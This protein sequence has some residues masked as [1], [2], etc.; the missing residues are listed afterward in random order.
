MFAIVE[1]G[2]KQYMVKEGSIL[3]VE[4]IAAD[5]GAVIDINSILYSYHS[6]GGMPTGLTK[7]I[8]EVLEHKRS[9]KIIVFK[10]KRRHNYRR[11]NGHRQDVTVLRVKSIDGGNL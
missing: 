11:K 6:D 4:R 10:K 9:K 2:S 3:I 7:V 8:A 5:V 1:E